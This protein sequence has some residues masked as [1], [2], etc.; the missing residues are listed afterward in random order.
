VLDIQSFFM[1]ITPATH[2]QHAAPRDPGPQELFLG[3]KKYPL[4]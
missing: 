3:P 1:D 2:A 4:S